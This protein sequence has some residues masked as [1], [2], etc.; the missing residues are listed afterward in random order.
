MQHVFLNE[1]FLETISYPDEKTGRYF[2]FWWLQVPLG[3]L[4][5]EKN[6]H[7]SVN[8]L[9]NKILKSISQTL[10]QYDKKH[11]MSKEY[12]ESFLKSDAFQ[13][14]NI[15]TELFVNHSESEIPKQVEIS[16]VICT[17]N[18]PDFLKAC[19]QSLLFQSSTPN[20]IIIIDNAPPNNNSEKI[21]ENYPQLK[22][23]KENRRGLDIA[24][25]TG[26]KIARCPIVAFIDDDV[27]LHPNW[28]Y[29]V[30][31][32]FYSNSID[33]MTG[34][35]L[36]VSLE[37]ESQQLF[38]KYWGFN[39]GYR[40]ILFDQEFIK[41]KA[42][43]VWD[44]G[45]GVNMA[46]RKNLLEKVNYFDER[47]DV[48]AAGCNGDSEIWFRILSLGSKII[49][50]PRAVLY[51]KH[52]K[53]MRSLHTQIFSYTRGHV[54]A[55]LFQHDQNK[56]I[57]YKK[58]VFQDLGKYYILLLRLGFP[59]YRSRYRTLWTEIKGIFSGIFFYYKNK[60]MP[61]IQLQNNR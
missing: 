33:A 30:W 45:A 20:E 4:Y 23:Y 16:V 29:Q 52:R 42:P 50:N 21:T 28:T 44:I 6:I 7:I 17:H 46:F 14:N 48:G 57:G 18:R 59:F 32:S 55:A 38:E 5:I 56:T 37:T 11:L 12:K 2:I 31:K 19:I 43:R 24:R 35:T 54:A 9:K 3:N 22:Y 25:N 53:D 40:E 34:L 10:D 36:P 49:Y 47:L 15:M 1:N 26:A 39:K 27:E 61:R 13:F 51:H 60:R 41:N 58:Y 8:E